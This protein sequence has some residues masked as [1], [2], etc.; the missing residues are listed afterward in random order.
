MRLSDGVIT[1][2]LTMLNSMLAD[3][4]CGTRTTYLLLVLQDLRTR[5]AV[6][7]IEA[8]R[9]QEHAAGLYRVEA[10]H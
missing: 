5:L 6:A 4:E 1:D 8:G 2:A 7:R 10:L 9:Y 3:N